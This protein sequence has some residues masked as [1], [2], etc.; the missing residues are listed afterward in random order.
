MVEVFCQSQRD[1]CPGRCS[2][3]SPTS[4]S[5][6]PAFGLGFPPFSLGC[7]PLP[8]S[9]TSSPPRLCTVKLL[10]QNN[11][12][13]C[14]WGTC[15]F[16]IDI[17]GPRWPQTQNAGPQSQQRCIPQASKAHPSPWLS[18]ASSLRP[19]HQGADGEARWRKLFVQTCSEEINSS[20][21]EMLAWEGPQPCPRLLLSFPSLSLESDMDPQGGDP[22]N[23]QLWGLCESQNT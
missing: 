13:K 14:S 22:K 21:A 18:A 20:A 7:S 15:C 17:Q 11:L 6:I 5:P 16:Q 4:S 2:L 10:I 9:F 8:T 19:N 23:Q 3:L 12:I 1:S